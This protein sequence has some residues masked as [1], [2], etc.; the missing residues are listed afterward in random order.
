MALSDVLMNLGFRLNPELNQEMKQKQI[1]DRTWGAQGF[2]GK[3]GK[4]LEK[5]EI[6]P[7]R[8]FDPYTGVTLPRLGIVMYCLDIKYEY[9]LG[10]GY[11]ITPEMLYSELP[12]SEHDY[13]VMKEREGT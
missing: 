10:E 3:C 7:E 13:W 8:G 2:C 4:Q 12:K 6:L 9:H 1:E 5:K 11:R